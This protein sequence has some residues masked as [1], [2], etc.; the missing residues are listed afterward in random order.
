MKAESASPAKTPAPAPEKKPVSPAPAPAAPEKPVS[1]PQAP[2]KKPEAKKEGEKKDGEKK[3][4]GQRYY[5]PDMEVRKEIARNLVRNEDGIKMLPRAAITCDGNSK[6]IKQ[7][8]SDELLKWDAE[9]QKGAKAFAGKLDLTREQYLAKNGIIM[10]P[11]KLDKLEKK[12]ALTDAGKEEARERLRK[13]Y[14]ESVRKLPSE[15]REL[16]APV[17]RGEKKIS[18]GALVTNGTLYG[19]RVDHLW[20]LGLFMELKN[21]RELSDYLMS[22]N[23]IRKNPNNPLAL[24]TQIGKINCLCLEKNLTEALLYFGLEFEPLSESDRL[25]AEE[26]AREYLESEKP[27]EPSPPEKKQIL[28]PD[29]LVSRILNTLADEFQAGGGELSGKVTEKAEYWEADD[30]FM[31]IFER[32]KIHYKNPLLTSSAIREKLQTFKPAGARKFRIK[33]VKRLLLLKGNRINGD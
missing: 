18:S 13:S 27:A 10:E 3:P 6:L 19:F 33:A 32:I 24:Y 9:M 12:P 17:L 4:A 11:G 31:V 23:V 25:R 1:A 21:F 8:K 7:K 5:I 30:N 16:F 26:G 14:L 22:N 29:E 2:E 20:E 15:I 28:S